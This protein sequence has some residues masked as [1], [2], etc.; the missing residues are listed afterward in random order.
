MAQ[1][2]QECTSA[3]EWELST[4][5]LKLWQQPTVYVCAF[6]SGYIYFL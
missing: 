4:Y 3:L 5:I 1:V 2:D 6:L